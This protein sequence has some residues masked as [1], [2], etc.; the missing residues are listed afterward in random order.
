MRR[1]ARQLTPALV[2]ELAAPVMERWQVDQ[3]WLYGSV[4][5]GTQRAD[6]DVDIVFELLPGVRMGMRVWYFQQDLE[7]ALGVP[8]DVQKPPIRELC[9]PAFLRGYD[10]DRVIIYECAAR[11]QS[12][13]RGDMARFP[14]AAAQA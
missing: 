12:Q 4:A 3:A 2:A 14:P 11:R 7:E 13:G 1:D 6:S 10:R 5:R 9:R 8:V